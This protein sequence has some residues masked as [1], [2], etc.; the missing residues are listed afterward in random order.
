MLE[1]IGKCE[2]VITESKIAHSCAIAR[3]ARVAE[4]NPFE[5]IKLDFLVTDPDKR[6]RVSHGSVTYIDFLTKISKLQ[7]PT[8]NPQPSPFDHRGI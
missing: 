4:N 5:G 7:N 6:L 1:K 8:T 2:F 3:I